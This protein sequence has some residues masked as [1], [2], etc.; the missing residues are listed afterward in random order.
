MV[1]QARMHITRL[2][3]IQLA[4]PKGEEEKARAFY[5]GL[6]GIPEEPKPSNLAVRGGCWFERGSLKIHL[7][8]DPEFV[9][10]R[11]AHPAFIV[12]ELAKLIETL[13]AA[14][15]S[16]VDDEPLIGYARCYISDPFGNRIELME[17]LAS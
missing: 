11:K 13:T 9:P 10:A 17:Q 12:M 14:G 15:V 1:G 3:H 4:M 2:D 7:G 8:I 5:E 16:V 6:L